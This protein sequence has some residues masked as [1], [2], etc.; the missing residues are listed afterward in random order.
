MRLVSSEGC[1][2]ATHTGCLCSFHVFRI[3]RLFTSKACIAPLSPPATSILPSRRMFPEYAMSS[4]PKREMF[5]TTFRVLEEKICTRD[6]VVTANRSCDADSRFEGGGGG[7]E[8]WVTGEECCDGS[9]RS[10]DAKEFQYFCSDVS[11]EG[12]FGSFV[13]CSSCTSAAIVG[14]LEL[15]GVV[16][17]L[18]FAI[19]ET[20]WW[21]E[22]PWANHVTSGT[23]LCRAQTPP[24][25]SIS[26]RHG[27]PPAPYEVYYICLLCAF[28]LSQHLL[29]CSRISV[30]RRCALQ[31]GA[32]LL[33]EH[34]P[35]SSSITSRSIIYQASRPC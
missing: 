28:T 27:T 26:L 1:H 35:P 6:P 34:R 22:R 32:L 15:L 11:V 31:L 18:Q 4:T 2:C 21:R 14:W 3:A 33:P 9:S 25:W 30:V 20:F 7:I 19:H 17:L 5:L 12:P 8:M 13:G 29:R 10:S 23:A 24:C 16:V